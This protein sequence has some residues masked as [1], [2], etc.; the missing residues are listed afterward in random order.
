MS[1]SFRYVFGPV[2]SR[3]LGRSLG[4]DLVPHKT[5]TYDCIYCQ[6]GRTTDKTLERKEYAPVDEI[7][8]E[9]DRRLG[10]D[11]KPDFIT[12]SGGGEPTLHRGIGEIIARIK[13]LTRKALTRIPIAVLTN[14]SL[15]WD[16][17]VRDALGQADLVVPSLDA[18]DEGLFA[19][20]NRPHPDLSFEKVVRGLE[21][22]RTSFRGRVWLEVLLLGG[23]TGFPSVVEKIAGIARRIRP[24]RVQLNTVA[25]PPAEEY[26]LP[27]AAERLEEL[28]RAFEGLAEVIA[29]REMPSVRSGEETSDDAIVALLRRRPCSLA[30]VAGGLDIH[31]SEAAKRLSNLAAAGRVAVRR[32]DGGVFYTAP[33]EGAAP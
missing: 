15:L 12:L 6:L 27:V 22:F 20:V 10:A 1:S 2:P 33:A 7:A 17:E 23:V 32:S 19:Y 14:G 13:A 5:C 9:I 16:E 11:P 4:V 8:A 29:P 26:A 30:D 21:T 18:S 28:A 3:R 25:R 24:D 31:V